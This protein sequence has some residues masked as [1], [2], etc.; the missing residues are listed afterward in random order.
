MV[1]LY[2]A[3]CYILG[4]RKR[5]F[6][7][8][9][10]DCKDLEEK[11]RQYNAEEQEKLSVDILDS[12]LLTEYNSCKKLALD[13][14]EE[15]DLLKQHVYSYDTYR[16]KIVGRASSL[17]REI[18]GLLTYYFHQLPDP[19]DSTFWNRGD[20]PA[21]GLKSEIRSLKGILLR[22]YSKSLLS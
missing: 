10:E 13:V 5:H 7:Q 2:N 21:A 14:K 4:K 15:C 18:S 11:C 19:S 20:S 12:D 8:L 3:R 6:I 22:S 16:S 1:K 9:Q 17:V